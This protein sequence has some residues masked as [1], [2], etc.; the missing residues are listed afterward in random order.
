MENKKHEPINPLNEN[1]GLLRE[2]NEINIT[3]KLILKGMIWFGYTG[4]MSVVSFLIQTITGV[5]LAF[6][7]VPDRKEALTSIQNITHT[8]PFGCFAQRIHAVGPH[9]MIGMVIIHTIDMFLKGFYRHPRELYW[10]SGSFLFI[11]TL[12]MHYTGILLSV[13]NINEYAGIPLSFIY[14]I[15]VAFIPLTMGLLMGIHCFRKFAQTY[16][17]LKRMLSIRSSKS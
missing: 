14:A 4:E 12:L 15:H 6:Y 5:F 3:R 8:V 1:R 13:V 11:L 10:V 2:I 17:D 7:F 16:T 9:I